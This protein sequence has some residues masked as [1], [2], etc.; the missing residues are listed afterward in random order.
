[1]FEPA[2]RGGSKRSLNISNPT[3][4]WPRSPGEMVSAP[5]RAA[6]TQT[7][8]LTRTLGPTHTRRAPRPPPL[9]PSE[10]GASDFISC[11]LDFN[12]PAG[13]PLA[14]GEPAHPGWSF[15]EFR[16]LG[17]E[18][19]GRPASLLR[20]AGPRSL[21]HNPAAPGAIARAEAGRGYP[22]EVPC[23]PRAANGAPVWASVARASQPSPAA[24]V[25]EVYFV[26]VAERRAR[27]SSL[28]SQPTLLFPT[29]LGS[30]MWC[31]WGF[32]PM[33]SGDWCGGVAWWGG[34]QSVLPVA[35]ETGLMDGEVS[36]S[37]FPSLSPHR[38]SQHLH[39]QSLKFG[40]GCV[41]P[42]D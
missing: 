5:A 27:G 28:L 19:Q 31:L 24:G 10:L 41:L 20:P 29:R 22:R 15:P 7:H 8:A 35:L 23:A 21:G 37:G 16:V 32:R 30:E 14:P 1:M 40:L 2:C 36:R 3:P 13:F 9:S 4:K 11:F 25:R 39:P 26:R 6:D 18:E 12:L 34:G 38:F 17:W 42:T 33:R